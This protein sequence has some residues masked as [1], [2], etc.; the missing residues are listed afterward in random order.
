MSSPLAIG[1]RQRGA[2]Q[3]A[4]QRPDRSGRG[5]GRTVN[6]SAVA[7][8]TIDLDGADEPPRLNLFLY[9]VTPNP[10][11]RNAACRRAA[12]ATASG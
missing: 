11:W 10:G 8:D 2:A 5:D 9:Q 7:P 12:P 3:P 6:V 1:A 4:R